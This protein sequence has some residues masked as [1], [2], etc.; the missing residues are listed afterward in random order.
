[1]TCRVYGL[2]FQELE[3]PDSEFLSSLRPAKQLDLIL[4]ADCALSSTQDPHIITFLSQSSGSQ[5][6][7]HFSPHVTP[8]LSP[9]SRT[10]R[11]AASPTG[12]THP[13]V[14]PSGALSHCLSC[15]RTL[16]SKDA[17]NAKICL[18]RALGL[19]CGH[20]AGSRPT[21]P[22]GKLWGKSFP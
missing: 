6:S 1:M 21:G 7:P 18:S 11:L 10:S 5:P 13:A 2:H 9:S 3:I 16:P 8:T 4:A 22:I 19:E 15:C 20:A 14:Q 12:Q 17:E